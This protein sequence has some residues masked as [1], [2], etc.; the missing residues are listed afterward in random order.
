MNPTVVWSKNHKKKMAFREDLDPNFDQGLEKSELFVST[1]SNG[2]GKKKKKR[3][4]LQNLNTKTCCS[5]TLST[6]VCF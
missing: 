4:Q 1:S 6:Q 5:P 2:R 3:I